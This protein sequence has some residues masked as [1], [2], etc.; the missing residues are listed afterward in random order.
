MKTIP[1]SAGEG[2]TAND[3]AAL[4]A[5]QEI[6]STNLQ[7]GSLERMRPGQRAM[8]GSAGRRLGYDVKD[9]ETDYRRSAPNRGSAGAA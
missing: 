8:L 7:P 1:P 9:W 6:F 2:L 3:F 5:A 4:N